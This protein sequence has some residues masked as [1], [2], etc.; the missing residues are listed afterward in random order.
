MHRDAP[1]APDAPTPRPLYIDGEPTFGR[2]RREA[3]HASLERMR[4]SLLPR[5][6]QDSL[7]DN[8]ITSGDS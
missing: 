6:G 4:Q 3:E 5:S 1:D 8:E 2:R 7:V